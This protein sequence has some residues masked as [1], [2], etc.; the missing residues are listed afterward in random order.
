MVPI[1][2]QG[3]GKGI[4]H[5]VSTFF[6]RFD[7]LCREHL[8]LKRAKAFAFI[9]YSFQDQ[10]L[11]KILK[12]EGAF[13]QL[14]RLSGDRLS[15]FYLHSDHEGRISFFNTH[16]LSKLGILGEAAP[17]CVVFFKL[18]DDKISDISVAQLD[19]A[20]LIH[21]LHELYTIIEDYV[22][23]DSRE[24][25]VQPRALGWIKGSA[26]FVGIEAFRAALRKALE[27]LL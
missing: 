26:R 8:R 25:T 7:E 14:D 19:S 9:F 22:E 20:N 16:F 5:N 1:F 2:E 6:E 10:A 15:I 11:R 4:G 13:V 27:H 24:L 23:A 3:K 12:D 18:E 21:G 17:P